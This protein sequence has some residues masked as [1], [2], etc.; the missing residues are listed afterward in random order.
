MGNLLKKQIE[1]GAGVAPQMGGL[2][3][4]PQTDS[5]L[6]KTLFEM[7]GITPDKVQQVLNEVVQDA[8]RP[9]IL[10]WEVE[11]IVK[12]TTFKKS[13]L[14][15][16]I[17]CDPR[18]R[19]YERRRGPRGKRVWLCEPTARAIQDIIMNEWD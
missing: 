8:A 3:M 16:Y 6:I 2:S 1:E 17:L 11:D 19:R 13:F 14:E 5:E 12:A 18:I 9:V 7:S 15:E 4:L 10:F